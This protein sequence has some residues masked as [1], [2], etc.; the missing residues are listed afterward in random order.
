MS[1][2]TDTH[3]IK[4]YLF[5]NKWTLRGDTFYGCRPVL[6]HDVL[7]VVCRVVCAK[8]VGATSSDGFLVN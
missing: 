4:M 8:V 6:P 5:V 2:F 7:L 3:E 1:Q